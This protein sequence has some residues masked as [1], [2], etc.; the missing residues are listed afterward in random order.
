MHLVVELNIRLSL[1]KAEEKKNIINPQVEIEFKTIPFANR[2]IIFIH[3]KY[4]IKASVYSRERR[5]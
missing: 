5:T 3:L 1:S 4:K 2:I